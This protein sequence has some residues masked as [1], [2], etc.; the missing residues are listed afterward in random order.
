M[1][2]RGVLLPPG[3]KMETNAR[4]SS[5]KRRDWLSDLVFSP[6][7]ATLTDWSSHR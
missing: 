4:Q 7:A 6:L 3:T 1:P 5:H 2:T